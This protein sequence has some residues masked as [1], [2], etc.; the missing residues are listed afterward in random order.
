[1][2][3]R[4]PNYVRTFRKKAGLSQRELGLILGYRDEGEVSRHEHFKAV[5]PLELALRYEALFHVPVSTIFA[6]L[7]NAAA[8]DTERRMNRLETTLKVPNPDRKR[9][10]KVRRKLE[11][12]LSRKDG[13]DIAELH[14]RISPTA[15][16]GMRSS[17]SETS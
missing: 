2:T 7:Y 4:L 5:P 13:R 6:G 9:E 10:R 12:L 1:M 8:R 3:Q 17:T 15:A 16:H 14:A 11:W